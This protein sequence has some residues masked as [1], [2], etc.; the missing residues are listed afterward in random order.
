M[1]GRAGG[2]GVGLALSYQL[3]QQA[4]GQLELVRTDAHGTSFRLVLGSEA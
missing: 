1:N 4:G 3:A 2:S